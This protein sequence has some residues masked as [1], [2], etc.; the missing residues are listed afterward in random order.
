VLHT[1]MSSRLREVCLLDAALLPMARTRMDTARLQ[2]E[3]ER[4]PERSTALGAHVLL[5]M[6]M[7]AADIVAIGAESR[8]GGARKYL[9]PVI[10]QP[11][12]H[13]PGCESARCL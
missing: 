13:R 8:R 10:P 12:R 3:V 5:G 7:A 2:E 6:D 11:F 9:Q 4:A 1:G